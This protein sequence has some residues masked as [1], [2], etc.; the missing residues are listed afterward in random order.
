M[1]SIEAR[2]NIRSIC[3]EQILSSCIAE[4]SIAQ[5]PIMSKTCSH[6]TGFFIEANQK[7][8]VIMRHVECVMY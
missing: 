3:S 7:Q 4:P 5:L 6:A 1:I 2:S 8:L